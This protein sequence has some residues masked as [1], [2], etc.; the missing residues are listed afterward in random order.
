M[1]H[2]ILLSFLE[3]VENCNMTYNIQPTSTVQVSETLVKSHFLEFWMMKF[4]TQSI[5]IECSFERKNSASETFIG[6]STVSLQE[7]STRVVALPLFKITI[8]T[9][10]IIKF[11]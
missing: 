2:I 6:W 7:E 8:S 1:C 11:L 3:F 10:H 4:S 9:T 5:F